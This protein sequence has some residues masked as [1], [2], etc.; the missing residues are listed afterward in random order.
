MSFFLMKRRAKSVID[1][2]GHI[3]KKVFITKQR[4]KNGYLN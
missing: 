2:T 1:K 4:N 3:K